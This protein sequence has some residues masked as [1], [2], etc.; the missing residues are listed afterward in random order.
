[1][2]FIS[3]FKNFKFTNKL[4]DKT[5]NIKN[6]KLQLTSLIFLFFIDFFI[7]ISIL[8]LIIYVVINNFSSNEINLINC[9]SMSVWISIVFNLL[10]K[11]KY[12]NKH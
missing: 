6:E 10:M 11:M 9:F 2:A 12:N 7:K 3:K 4:I 8:S 1:M 5:F